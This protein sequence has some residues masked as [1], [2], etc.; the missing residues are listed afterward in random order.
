MLARLSLVT[1][2]Y[3]FAAQSSYT[4]NNA[5]IEMHGSY[6]DETGRRLQGSAVPTPA[7]TQGG[8]VSPVPAATPAP[9]PAPTPQE[10]ETK[11]CYKNVNT[12]LDN[13]MF[14]GFPQSCFCANTQSIGENTRQHSCT[15]D[16]FACWCT[17]LAC[18]AQHASIYKDNPAVDRDEQSQTQLC[19]KNMSI[20]NLANTSNYFEYNMAINIDCQKRLN[21]TQTNYRFGEFIDLGIHKGLA[22]N[23]KG[24]DDSERN[25]SDVFLYY[26]N[27]QGG[28]SSLSQNLY[29]PSD[30]K[31]N[32]HPIVVSFHKHASH[33]GY[34]LF[35]NTSIPVNKQRNSVAFPKSYIAPNPSDKAEFAFKTPDTTSLFS[36][37]L[38]QIPKKLIIEGVDMVPLD[39]D[40]EFWEDTWYGSTEKR[41]IVIATT[42]N[43]FVYGSQTDNRVRLHQV[44]RTGPY[45]PGP[46]RVVSQTL[47]YD[48]S[49]FRFFKELHSQTLYDTITIATCVC[50]AIITLLTFHF[51][52]KMNYIRD[53]L[54]TLSVLSVT[55]TLYNIAVYNAYK[56]TS[57]FPTVASMLNDMSGKAHNF[58][59]LFLI[60]VAVAC[61]TLSLSF[62]ADDTTKIF[63]ACLLPLC[64]IFACMFTST[65]LVLVS[66]IVANFILVLKCKPN[67]KTLSNYKRF[68][69]FASILTSSLFIVC[70]VLNYTP[71]SK[72]TEY[73]EYIYTSLLLTFFVLSFTTITS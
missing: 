73:M 24:T 50:V 46:G 26:I 12:E 69:N 1:G 33:Q 39:E 43:I 59:I 41:C 61:L 13:P 17:N 52:R 19:Q 35:R 45:E 31:L 55:L 32:E 5:N 15:F 8:G 2:L 53:L 28:Y 4:L 25:T 14:Y 70:C 48:Y 58:T 57:L 22:L 40:D 3:A 34:M 36:T 6:G 51:V 27:Q 62:I 67:S 66:S 7:P 49:D 9:T 42:F 64:L 68:I 72:P 71:K 56:A 44:C 18:C 30:Q 11:Q 37:N 29:S 20:T 60:C 10:I 38:I 16:R 21:A 23:Y 47:L 54:L 63:H 65:I